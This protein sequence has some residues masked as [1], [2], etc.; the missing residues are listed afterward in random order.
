MLFLFIKIMKCWKHTYL[1]DF[2]NK[3]KKNPKSLIILG[4]GRQN[5]P[6]IYVR[7]LIEAIIFAWSNAN[8]MINCFNISVD[9]RTTVTRIAEIVAEEMGLKDVNFVYTGGDRGWV[10]DVPEFQYD[11][12]RISNL[13]WKAKRTS[14]EAI[15][16]AVRDELGKEV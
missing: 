2:I 11:I 16:I 7:D 3:L 13:G 9:N 1:F 8:D 14:E 6:Y 5:K 4:D 15:R 12:S 10:G